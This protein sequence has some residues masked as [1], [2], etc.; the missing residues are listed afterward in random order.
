MKR[1]VFVFLIITIT[2]CSTLQTVKKMKSKR[3]T[4]SEWKAEDKTVLFIPMIHIAN[5]DFYNS[6]RKIIESKKAEGFIVYYEGTKM[7]AVD[8]TIKK[9]LL[10]KPYVKYYHGPQ[11]ID[12][13]C[14]VVYRKKINKFIGFIPDSTSRQLYI[15][16]KGFFSGMV[17]QP[18]PK[19]LGTDH[20]DRNVDV[21]DNE[22]VDTYE[23]WF[24]EIM[25]EEADFTIMP[26][27]SYPKSLR[28]PKD[29]V[30]SILIN[31]RDEYLA[32]RIQASTDK[33]I[34]V[35]FGMAHM[36]GTFEQLKRLDKRW[37]K[38]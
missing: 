19:V 21:G 5:P 25:L 9:Q 8:D 29:N 11:H 1:Y 26:G 15:P 24:G 10:D 38:L 34:L 20:N 37:H 35:L 30:K 3:A 27:S 18:T 6:V 12:S 13:I 28:L 33:K 16:K 17:V 23:K 36:G 14:Q 2:A 22:M 7:K 4:V 31:Y 32:Q